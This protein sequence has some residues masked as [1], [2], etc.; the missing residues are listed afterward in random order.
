MR[1]AIPLDKVSV[2][3]TNYDVSPDSR[4]FLMLNPSEQAQAPR[5]HQRGAELV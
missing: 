5:T 4:R 3:I 1:P 2:P